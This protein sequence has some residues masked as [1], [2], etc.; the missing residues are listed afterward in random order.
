MPGWVE[1]ESL[2]SIKIDE[3]QYAY[4]ITIKRRDIFSW[5]EASG[6]TFFHLMQTTSGENQILNLNEAC[7]ATVD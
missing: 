3:G 7:S 4:C 2:P 6:Q 5:W 1:I